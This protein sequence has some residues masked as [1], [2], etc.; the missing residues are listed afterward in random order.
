MPA[1]VQ[2]PEHDL[3]RHDSGRD[4]QGERHPALVPVAAQR[5]PRPAVGVA[6]LAQAR[7]GEGELGVDPCGPG[8]VAGDFWMVLEHPVQRVGLGFPL[9][10]VVRGRAPDHPDQRLV[11]VDDRMT[12]GG[13]QH[14]IPVLVLAARDG[15][16]D[17]ADPVGQGLAP[18]QVGRR[19]HHHHAGAEQVRMRDLGPA[20]QPRMGRAREVHHDGAA[21][22]LRI[23]PG[24]HRLDLGAELTR[25]PFVVVIAERDEIGV[26]H[27]DAG[28]A[29]AGQAWRPGVDRHDQAHPVGQPLVRLGPV[30]HHHDAELTR[31]IL[32]EDGGE[33]SAQRTRPI[34]RRHHHAHRRPPG[35]GLDPMYP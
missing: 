10:R 24:A 13:P 35:H 3:A 8:A 34:V 19:V 9:P 28:V 22:E 18:G 30:V 16:V 5:P 29:G 25:Q 23:R 32:G 26:Q 6:S 7:V 17:Q 1:G 11:H 33:R 12:A 2:V 31:V 15:L 21:R 27:G 14:E 4:R 20:S